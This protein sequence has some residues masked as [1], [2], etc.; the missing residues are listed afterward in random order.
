MASHRLLQRLPMAKFS[1]SALLKQ[2]AS[3]SE[4]T[5]LDNR[6]NAT[7]SSPEIQPTLSSE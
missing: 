4:K 5:M 7:S 6:A 3:T 1:E 2:H